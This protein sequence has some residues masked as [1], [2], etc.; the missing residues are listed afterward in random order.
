MRSKFVL[1][2]I[3]LCICVGLLWQSSTDLSAQSKTPR[4]TPTEQ[5][6]SELVQ[7]YWKLSQNAKFKEADKL[8]TKSRKGFSYVDRSPTRTWS[9]IISSTQ[10]KFLKIEQIRVVDE[11]EIEVA[12]KVRDHAGKEFHLFHTVVKN[13][14]DW[15]IF[16]TTY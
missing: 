2:G 12:S 11:T 9:E 5:K 3:G 7:E 14:K 6:V 15:K 10:L 16:A 4:T 8:T 13:G 1:L